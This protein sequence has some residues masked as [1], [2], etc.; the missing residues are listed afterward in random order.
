MR[1]DERNGI[2]TLLITLLASVSVSAQLAQ[3]IIRYD[4][5]HNPIIGYHGMAVSQ[6]SIAT[7]VGHNV[8]KQGG[9]AVDAAV[10]MGFALSV[11]LPR[12]GNLGGGG[13]MLIHLADSDETIALDYR[14]MAP[15]SSN[16]ADHRSPVGEIL[17][18]KLT[19][20]A[21]ASAI[22]GTLAGL[23]RA[24]QRYGSLP[25]PELVQP[26]IDLA[27]NGIRVTS[28]LSFALEAA[29]RVLAANPA[30]SAIYLRSDGYAWQPGQILVQKDLAWSLR[31]IQ[32]GGANAFYEGELGKRIVAALQNA[33]RNVSLEDLKAYQAKE[34]P[35]VSTNYRGYKV[36]SMPPPSAGGITLLQMLN[37][38]NRFDVEDTGAGS[39]KHLHL[40]SET[41]KLAAA[42]RRTHI[43]DP[44][45]NDL[46][47]DGYIGNKLAADLA[48]EIDLKR[49]AKVKNIKPSPVEQYESRDTTHFSVMDSAG[50][51]VSNTYTLGYSFG[52]GWVAEG[53]GILLDNQMRN[54]YISNS[55]FGPNAFAPGKR[56]LSTMTP[57]IVLD[58]NDEVFLTTGTPGGSRI[59]NTVLQLLINII[60]FDMNIAEAT[61]RPRI[62]QGWNSQTL[63]LEQ[64][65]SPDTIALLK[66][67]GHEVVYEQTMGST[68][69]I[70][71]RDGKYFGS[72][73][74]RR[75]DALAIGVIMPPP[76]NPKIKTAVGTRSNP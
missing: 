44:D 21:H 43:G 47:I 2:A 31:Q 15:L 28:D 42:N 48:R 53:T 30:S 59:I 65:F 57:T 12:A 20:G 33:G 37:V 24:W 8:L 50:N 51:A 55:E 11:T 1:T 72:S 73:N 69:S 14:S 46:A 4:T 16:D 32:E 60:D 26:A 38:L 41:M 19:F 27:E 61:H 75:P 9:N 45:F 58:A 18:D 40:L 74:S 76:S 5:V 29:G 54:F 17:W 56:M 64:G 36:F 49:A 63:R 6:N 7:L 66:N 70:L 34:R 62:Q 23:H 39:A 3:P 25:W 52:S 22:P 10:A 35:V 13:F 71:Y 67:M 68:Q